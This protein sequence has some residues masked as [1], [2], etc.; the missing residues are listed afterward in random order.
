MVLLEAMAAGCPIVAT[1]VGGNS[2]AI[3][4]KVNGVLVPPREPS[5]LAESIVTLLNDPTLMNKYAQS[6]L[7][8]FKKNF[9]AEIMALEYE[10]LYK[11][12]DL[13]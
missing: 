11:L 2:I 9:S 4:D 7:N 6:S 1:N 5:A 10:K 3:K 12:V 8:I 13:K